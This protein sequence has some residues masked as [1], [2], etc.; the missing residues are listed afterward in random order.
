MLLNFKI[1]NLINLNIFNFTNLDREFF[2]IDSNKLINYNK[3]IC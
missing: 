3:Y 2:T 1:K